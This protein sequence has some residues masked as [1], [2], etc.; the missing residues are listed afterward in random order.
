MALDTKNI[1]YNGIT[2]STTNILAGDNGD[3]ILSKIDTAINT[4]NTAPDYTGFNL[5]CVKETDGITHPTNTQNFAEGISK[6]LCDFH[7][8]YN[9]FTGTTYVNDLNTTTTAITGLQ[10]P[11]LTYAPYSITSGMTVT[12]V[13]NAL[14]TG[15][16]G[17]IT[18]IDPYTANWSTISLTPSHSVVTTWNNV[19][20]YLSSLSSTVAGKQATIGTFNATAIGGGA[21]DSL[22][23]TVN[24]L[25][26]YAAGLPTFN[27]SGYTWGCVT[28]NSTLNGTLQNILNTIASIGNNYVAGNGSGLTIATIG[29]CAGKSLALDTTNVGLYK[30]MLSTGDTYTN[31]DYLDNKISST[32]GSITFSVSGNKLNLEVTNPVSYQVKVTST[33][34]TPNY[35]SNKIVSTTD[36]NWGLSLNTSVNTNNQLLLTP[37]VGNPV[38]HIAS[39][40][41]F[42]SSNPDLLQQF[43]ELVIQA[44]ANPG[45]AV[46]TLTVALGGTSLD[47]TWTHQSGTAQNAKFRQYGTQTWFTSGFNTANPMS[48]TAASNV[49][50]APNINTVYDFQIDTVYSGGTVSGNI[51]QGVYYATQ[52]LTSSVTAGVITVTQNP[53]MLDTIQYRLRNSV[54]AV[55][56]N[57]NTTGLNPTISFSSVASG[58]YTVQW[59]YGSVVNGST[60]Y[61]D[62]A[63]QTG[64]WF[65]SGTITVP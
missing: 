26:S 20:S 57:V 33:D 54:P 52:S 15:L 21:T 58:N 59:R 28:S 38:L 14:F 7:T 47:L 63:S 48:G 30:V 8:A 56:Q 13:W 24:E 62:D 12:Q 1:Q 31:A 32:G 25:I 17:T 51:Y 49:F 39:E 61:S 53:V 50:A 55:I 41:S 22:T 40:M 35:L 42:I 45:A 4:H 43:N 16:T 60:L 10:N 46:S 9:T 19:I 44:A 5:Y 11:S 27:S 34:S 3:T 36:G 37:T 65:T 2:L 23:T 29:S 18:S 64:N 6:N